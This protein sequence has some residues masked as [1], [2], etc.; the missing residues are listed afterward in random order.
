MAVFRQF[1]DKKIGGRA[2]V[3][4]GTGLALIWH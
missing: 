3:Q 4:T 2:R 1:T